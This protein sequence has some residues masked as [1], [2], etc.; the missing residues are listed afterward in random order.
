[1]KKTYKGYY[2]PT[3]R[4]RKPC[5]VYFSMESDVEAILHFKT[6]CSLN[7]WKP[8]NVFDPDGK[9][10]FDSKGKRIKSDGDG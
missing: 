3:S 5:E 6:I 4:S 10:L 2:L 9:A 7:R 1:M 8:L